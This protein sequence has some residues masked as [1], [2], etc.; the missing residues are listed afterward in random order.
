[1]A[2]R[3]FTIR[4]PCSSANIGPGFDAIG[5]ALSIYLTLHVTIDP[6]A[7]APSPHPLNCAIAYEGEGG[8]A[9]VS[10]RP[11][12][13]LVTRVALYVLR[14]HDVRAFPH[15]TRLR[16]ANA[17][18]LGR[19]LG[20]SGAA[21]VAGVVLADECGRLGLP[22]ARMLDFCLMVERHPD[23]IAAALHGGF[24]GTYLRE[25]D[26]ADG[27]RL[28]IPLS[29]VLRPAPAGGVDTGLRPPAPPF[30]IGHYHRFRWAPE[31][32]CIAVIPQFE[33][34]TAKARAVLPAH[35][36]RADLVHN[37]QRIAL[38]PTALG[39]SP[40]DPDFIYLSMQ[41]RVH[42]PYRRAL[43]PGLTEI[44]QSITPRSH[45]GLLG[46]C[47]SGAGPTILALAT[48]NFDLI[49]GHLVAQF[50]KENIDCK[51]ALLEPA[52]DGTTEAAEE[53]AEQGTREAL[54][55]AAA[56]VSIDAGNALVEAIK[57]LVAATARPGSAAS[58]GGFGGLFDL[59][60][61]G[62]GPGAPRLVC[63][64]DG[65]GTKL[66]LAAELGR[67]DAVGVDLV[68]MNV[69]DVVVQGAEPLLFLDY[70][71]C[72]ALDVGAAAGFVAG[73]ARGCRDAGCALVGGET[74]EMPGLYAGSDYD[75]AGTAVGA[76][77]P[78]DTL[79]PDTP[80]M[81]PGDALLG[82][83]SSGPHANGFSLIRRVVE[84]AGLK[85]TDRAP[86]VEPEPEA[87]DGE[88]KDETAAVSVGECLLA[89]TRIYVRAV[90][91]L[92]AREGLLKGAAHVTG[93][94][95]LDNVPRMLPAHLRAELRAGAWE[96]PGVLR[97]LKREGG[98]R[99]EEFAR[100]WNAG[101]GM[102]VVV[103]EGRRD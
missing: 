42:Q 72:G 97:W 94:G 65:V 46:I 50:A 9:A 3:S 33:V 61:A 83:A 74:A 51:W 16:I 57:P 26:A 45:P 75:A 66:K 67:H 31:I 80:A 84:R 19:G 40:P 29:E 79:L 14:C 54:T 53:P 13:N 39:Q 52:L 68:A 20:S 90:R 23:N 35:Y 28:E 55:Y 44:L 82:L 103:G 15:E 37:L 71:A 30:G 4:A 70:Y 24:V 85:L 7:P 93:G 99:A 63:A 64:T 18:P 87:A 6:A 38:L 1:M 95:L 69:N 76:L 102:V 2:A 62:F 11:D 49:A 43:V 78:T 77:R 41:D 73:V 21:V 12:E 56:G 60:A 58:I 81:R 22:R 86:W 8:A 32:R 59:A 27:E 36:A 10:T 34:A 91:A 92:A 48:A 96:V 17:I 47:L 5:L 101:L 98:V 25:L 100:T 88:T 89:P